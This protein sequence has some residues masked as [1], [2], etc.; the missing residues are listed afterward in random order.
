VLDCRRV[1]SIING[2][3]AL[4]WAR[5]AFFNFVILYTVGRTLWT[6]DQPVVSSLPAHRTTQTQNK[7]TQ[8]SV[9]RVGFETTASVFEQAKTVHTLVRAA[10]V[11]GI[12]EFGIEM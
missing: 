12:E 11:T 8:I 1:H 3:K 6:G 10:A 4:C 2:S 7:S 5:A 9:P